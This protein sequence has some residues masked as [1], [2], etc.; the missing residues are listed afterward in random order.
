MSNIA[1][2]SKAQFD[3]M[4]HMLRQDILFLETGAHVLPTWT[5]TLQD[6]SSHHFVQIPKLAHLDLCPVRA[7]IELLNTRPLH[8]KAPLIVHRD[9]PFTQ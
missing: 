8:K 5:K 7:L 4:R 1:P 6:Y 9:P 3:P 2:H